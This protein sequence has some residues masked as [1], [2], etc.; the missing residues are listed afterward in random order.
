MT[1]AESNVNSPGLKAGVKMK[2]FNKAHLK[3]KIKKMML[4]APQWNNP[5]SSPSQK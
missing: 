5:I 3:I 2:G 4:Y 1:P